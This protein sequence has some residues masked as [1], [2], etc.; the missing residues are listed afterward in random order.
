MEPDMITL[1]V[2]PAAVLLAILFGT[3]SADEK[4]ADNKTLI[5]GVWELTKAGEGGPPVGTTMEFTKDGKLKLS[6]KADGKEF[7]F[8]GTYVIEGD[9]LTGTLK[10][11]DGTEKDTITIKKLTDKELVTQDENGRVVEFTRK[12]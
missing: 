3:L 7:A 12:K 4:K 6:G 2:V 8:D 9:K 11:Q 10:T 1:R 5:V